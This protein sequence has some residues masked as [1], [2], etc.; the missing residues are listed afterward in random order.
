MARKAISL[1]YCWT[2]RFDGLTVHL[3]SSETGAV[4]VALSLDQTKDCVD[5]F[6]GRWP[7]H[8]LLKNSAR[9]EALMEHVTAALRGLSPSVKLPFD[10]HLTA[11]Q[12]KV[13]ESITRIPFG[14]TLTY[15]QV[16]GMMG[17]PAASRAVGQALG[18][19]PLPL[20]FP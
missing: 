18:R 11:F 8:R 6:A 9:N 10:I 1:I 16:A 14:Q 15:G 13:L 2:L 4:R 5:H 19:N 7:A 3:A 12:E 17:R 20:I